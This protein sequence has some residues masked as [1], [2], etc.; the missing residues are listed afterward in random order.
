MGAAAGVAEESETDGHART[1]ARRRR[2]ADRHWQRQA[3]K[4]GWLAVEIG[5]REGEII[6]APENRQLIDNRHPPTHTKI[7][8][9]A[10]RDGSKLVVVVLWEYGYRYSCC[11]GGGGGGDGGGAAGRSA[12]YVCTYPWRIM[13]IY[14]CCGIT[15]YGGHNY[16][17]YG[18]YNTNT[19]TKLR[20]MKNT[21]IG[22][23]RRS[24]AQG[25]KIRCSCGGGS[26]LERMSSTPYP[27]S[28]QPRVESGFAGEW[29]R[30]A[31]C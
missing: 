12:P 5:K 26:N 2:Q 17:Q 30:R 15:P 22:Y 16:S 18:V 4:T 19:R 6:L 29:G 13:P 9:I 7:P 25:E 3:G 14:Y 27:G 10:L 31:R 21:H 23:D 8:G 20:S 1:H 28:S 11:G 24:G